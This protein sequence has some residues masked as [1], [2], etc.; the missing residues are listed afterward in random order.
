MNLIAR[1]QTRRRRWQDAFSRESHPD[2]ALLDPGR[3][4]GAEPA[5]ASHAP[6]RAAGRETVRVSGDLCDWRAVK[7]LYARCD[8]LLAAGQSAL[9]DLSPV[10]SA[11]SKLIAVLVSLAGR[12]R[13]TGAALEI[14]PS[15]EVLRWI[16]MCRLGE[17]LLDAPPRNDHRS[18]NDES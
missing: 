11:D 12:A 8:A 2:R 7:A 16:Q 9:I 18:S 15:V 6:Q 14:R 10:K 5:A 1:H 13:A 17:P 3:S 4:A